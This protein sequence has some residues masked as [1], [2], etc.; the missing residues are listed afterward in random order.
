MERIVETTTHAEQDHGQSVSWPARFAR[1]PFILQAYIVFILAATVLALIAIGLTPL[2]RVLIPVTGGVG[3]I[4]CA[5]T[6]YPAIATACTKQRKMIF[7]IL[8]LLAL[9]AIFGVIDLGS[10]LAA[11]DNARQGF[12]NPFLTYSAYRPIFIIT[13]PA[14]WLL[15]LVSPGMRRWLISSADDESVPARRQVSIADLLYVT[16]VVAACLAVSLALVGLVKRRDPWTANPPAA[17]PTAPATSPQGAPA[18]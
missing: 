1:A 9:F 2:N 6:L 4:L 14:A 7:G 11:P 3:L 10:H 16:F 12:N 13:L 17:A 8:P 15:L 5:F 18:K